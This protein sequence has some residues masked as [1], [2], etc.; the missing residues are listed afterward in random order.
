MKYDE[1]LAEKL[2]RYRERRGYTQK[3]IAQ[4]LDMS[5]SAY[6]YHETGKTSP[7]VQTIVRL[8]KLYGVT[9][10]ELLGECKDLK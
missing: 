3:Q 4:I 8:S 2:K 5:R 6:T 1:T 7:S 9:A 10:D